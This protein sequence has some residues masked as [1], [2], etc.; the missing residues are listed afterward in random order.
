MHI[1]FKHPGY[2]KIY[3]IYIN[4]CDYKYMYI[5]KYNYHIYL[6]MIHS[7]KYIAIYTQQKQE[8]L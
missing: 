5:Y 3:I 8:R 7:I 1:E 4:V 6:H 2:V